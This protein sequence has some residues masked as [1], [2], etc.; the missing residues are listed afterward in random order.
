[1]VFL[2]LNVFQDCLFKLI[3]FTIF[4]F[5]GRN[6]MKIRERKLKHPAAI[7]HKLPTR[8]R[9]ADLFIDEFQTF[10]EEARSPTPNS[11]RTSMR[12]IFAFGKM[13]LTIA[14]AKSP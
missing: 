10:G 2:F 8:V 3:F 6:T 9:I 11:L 1:M 5:L 13:L 12:W 7:D 4:I 14:A